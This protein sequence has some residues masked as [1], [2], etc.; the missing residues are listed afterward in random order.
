[1]AKEDFLHM[2][3]KHYKDTKHTSLKG[4]LLLI[5]VSWTQIFFF[6]F[7]FAPHLKRCEIW[8]PKSK[9]VLAINKELVHD[10]FF[11]QEINDVFATCTCI[12]IEILLLATTSKLKN[13][14]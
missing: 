2:F 10:T 11:A 8:V 3:E 9:A 14:M 1:M 4:Y 5:I 13:K 6:D 7:F 12:E